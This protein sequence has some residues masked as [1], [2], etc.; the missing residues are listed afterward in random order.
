[1][2]RG[3][4]LCGAV[5]FRLLKAVGPFEMC[6]CNR[7]RK[8]S[9]SSNLSMIGVVAEDYQLLCGKEQIC[10][11]SAP[12]LYTAPAYTSYFCK[13]CGSPTPPDVVSD[14]FEIPAGLLDDSP[15]IKPDRH[16]FTE[17]TPEWDQISDELPQYTLKQL[18][19][20]RH[21]KELPAKTKIKSHYDLGNA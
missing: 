3:S 19:R 11:Y 16:I 12:I 13:I 1:M 5:N 10:S 14:F 18:Y 4:C 2:I 17:F 9:G 15:G 6:H 8:K 21:G 20:L 7:C